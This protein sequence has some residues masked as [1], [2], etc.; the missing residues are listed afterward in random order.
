[1]ILKNIDPGNC[2]FCG[3]EPYEYVDVGIGMIPVAVT[4][5]SAGIAFFQYG[6][7]LHQIHKMQREIKREEKKHGHFMTKT[8]SIALE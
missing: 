3:C 8:E 5:C 6:K 2:P 7:T 1:M 4:C